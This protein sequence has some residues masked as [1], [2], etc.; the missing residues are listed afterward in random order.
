VVFCGGGGR[1]L[2][3]EQQDLLGLWDGAGSDTAL[4]AAM[5]LPGLWRKPRPGP[6]CGQESGHIRGE[7]RRVSLWRGRRWPKS[8]DFGE[9]GLY[10]AGSQL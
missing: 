6:E 2:V 3:P 1:P 9:T 4:R 10:E 5:E 7:F 8:C